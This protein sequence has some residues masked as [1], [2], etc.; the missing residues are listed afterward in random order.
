MEIMIKSESNK[1]KKDL[2]I[3]YPGDYFATKEDC[4]MGT[5]VGTSVAVCIYDPPR[6]IG[7]MV[8]FVVPGTIGTEG[9]ITDEIA[10]RGILSMEYLMGELVKIGGDRHFIRAK[11]FGAGYS[12]TG[13][14]NSGAIAESNIRFIHE[15]FTLEK[16]HVERSDMGGD[17]RRKIYF[18]PREGTVYRQILKNNEDSSEFMKMEKEYIDSEFRNKRQAG[19]VVL[20]E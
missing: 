10:R 1:F 13:I 5:V 19:R 15:Y 2:Y 11:I 12:N 3:L 9:I 7:G 4:M 17:F 6:R 14:A 18:E 20:F 16:I 8:L